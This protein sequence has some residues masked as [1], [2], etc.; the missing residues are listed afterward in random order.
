MKSHESALCA[1]AFL[2]LADLAPAQTPATQEPAK[3]PVSHVRAKEGGATLRN[4]ADAKGEVV[5]QAPAGALMAVYSERAG[6]L[7]VEPASGMKVWIFGAYLKRTGTPGLAEITA[8]NVRMRP[9]PSSDEKSFPLPMK[10]DRGERVRVIARADPVKPLGEDW[11]QVWSP[12][13]ARAFIAALETAPLAAGEDP[14]A[15]WASAIQEA[16]AAIPVVELALPS[17]RAPSVKTSEAAARKSEPKAHPAVDRLGEAEKLMATARAAENPDFAAAKAAYQ[18]VVAQSPQGASAGTARARLDEIAIREEIHRL[19]L[20][21]ESYEKQRVEKLS[22]AEAKLREV[23]KRQDPLWGR[24]QARGWL[25]REIKPG[26]LPR[27]VVRWSGKEVAELACGSGRYDLD[28]FVGYE[29]G[30]LG[31]TQRAAVPGVSDLPGTPARIDATRIE[32]ISARAG[33]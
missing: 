2:A 9:L 28:T 16:Q 19:K 26:E 31:V 11:V 24:F 10:L 4:L 12:A 6:W 27:Y 8:N 29:I 22:E 5:L 13:G 30:V 1:L 3:S 7:E 25:E 21:K 23:A 33:G 15:A 18:H 20:D 14:R 17:E 32:V